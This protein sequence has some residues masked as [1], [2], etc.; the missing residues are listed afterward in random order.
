MSNAKAALIWITDILKKHNIPF[1]I[2]GGLAANIYGAT[3]PLADIDIDMPEDKFALL[4]EEVKK[5]IIFG[6]EQY[7]SEKWDLLLMTLNYQ[8]QEIDLGGAYQT[9][10]FNEATGQW[11]SITEDLSKAVI[12][13]V[14][15][16]KAP[17]IPRE[18]LLAYKKVLSR[19]VDL[20]DVAEISAKNS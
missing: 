4:H 1:Q 17:V 16:I 14:M 20:I 19:E 2:S 5:F 15:G 8:G 6:P 18:T 13:D 11:Q 12:H 9:N 7:K 10:I 3:R